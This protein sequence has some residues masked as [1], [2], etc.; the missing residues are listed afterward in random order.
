MQE[1]IRC[2]VDAFIS[3]RCGEAFPQPVTYIVHFPH[4]S[5][6]HGIDYWVIENVEIAFSDSGRAVKALKGRAITGVDKTTADP[7]ARRRGDSLR[8]TEPER[9]QE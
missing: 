7:S 1:G 2:A 9:R 3:E 6:G 5:E 4:P 8:M